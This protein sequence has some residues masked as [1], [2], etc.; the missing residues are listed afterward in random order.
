MPNQG[1]ARDGRDGRGGAATLLTV[2]AAVGDCGAGRGSARTGSLG[3]IWS[4][5]SAELTAALTPHSRPKRRHKNIVAVGIDVHDCFVTTGGTG[6]PHDQRPHAV[7]S[8]VA[9]GHG[10]FI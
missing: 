5:I 10:C 2:A 9:E 7:L 8:H 3:P 1:M 6:A 4:N